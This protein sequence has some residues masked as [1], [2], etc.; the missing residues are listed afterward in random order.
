[1][2]DEELAIVAQNVG[3]RYDLEF[4]ERRTLRRTVASLGRRRA[5][6]FWALD[7][8][9]FALPRGEIL[10]VVGAN[11][12]GK[13]TLLLTIA[14]ILRPDR[15]SLSTFG[16]SSAL[17]T[18]GAGFE[19][20]LTGRENIYLSA[21][22]LGLS[23]KAT[24]RHVEPIVEFSELGGFI[25]VPVRKYSTG[26]RARLGFSIA[27]QI[28][29]D[30]LLLDEVLGVGDVAFKLKSKRK[31]REMMERARAIVIVSH[32]MDFI[33]ETCTRALWLQNGAAVALGPTAEIVDAYLAQAGVLQ[34]VAPAAEPAARAQPSGAARQGRTRQRAS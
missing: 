21:A 25:D 31:L 10:G 3:V 5:S 11:G 18:L 4:S 23:Q 28:E 16:R 24:A 9:T 6:P 32:S 34:S 30:I 2:I 12:S 15:G 27:S 33:L 13:S 22:Y 7:G 14:G 8:V 19:L 20:D 26:M 29:P 17:L 1:M